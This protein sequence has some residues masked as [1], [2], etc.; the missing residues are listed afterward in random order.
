MKI[1]KRFNENHNISDVLSSKSFRDELKKAIESGKGIDY[2][3]DGENDSFELKTS[4][5][6]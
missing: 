5:F 2:G 3:F 1:I 4:Y 6:I